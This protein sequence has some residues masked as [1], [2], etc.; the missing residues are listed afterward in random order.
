MIRLAKAKDIDIIMSITNACA[1]FMIAKGIHQWNEHYPSR[2]AFIN[3]F[4]RGELHVL[5]TNRGLIGSITI[6]TYMDKEYI[7]VEW[8]TN[9]ENN[10]YIHRLAIDPD[11][12]G[13]GHA[14][15]LM[16]YAERHAIKN[17]Y[18][19]I[20]LDTFSQNDRNQKFYELRGYKRLGNIY[21]PKQSEHPFY[22]YELV[23]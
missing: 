15:Q 1:S 2:D 16:E 8:L 18:S 5:E 10:L 7:P 4:E 21:F 19:S 9:S 6:S 12:Q 3:D 17:G 14:Q 22:C 20:R 23:L 11:H 13:Q